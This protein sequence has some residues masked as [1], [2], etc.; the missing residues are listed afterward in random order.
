M[1]QWHNVNYPNPIAPPSFAISPRTATSLDRLSFVASTDGILYP[2]SC[3][4]SAAKGDPGIT[5]DTT[6]KVVAV[7]FSDPVTNKACP[8]IYFP[9]M[10]VDG[11]VGPLPS[12][13]WIFRLIQHEGTNVFPFVVADVTRV[14]LS[15]AA[16]AAKQL[17]LSWPNGGIPLAVEFNSDLT[18]TNW[19]A[20]TNKPVFSGDAYT[21][22]IPQSAETRFFRLRRLAP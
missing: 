11:Q 16:T 3:Y 4:A 20:V 21:I 15:I 12:G 9:V 13:V 18:S 22:E 5:V 17:R 1:V 8:N 2:N 14:P 10:G 19:Q 6:N 7:S